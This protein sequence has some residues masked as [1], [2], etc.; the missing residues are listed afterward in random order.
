MEY[1]ECIWWNVSKIG[2]YLDLW[3]RNKLWSKPIISQFKRIQ[4]F[5]RGNGCVKKPQAAH[6]YPQ[7]QVQTGFLA[8]LYS[9]SWRLKSAFCHFWTVASSLVGSRDSLLAKNSFHVRISNIQTLNNSETSQKNML[10]SS[11]F[12]LGKQQTWKFANATC[13]WIVRYIAI[14]YLY[15]D[16][17]IQQQHIFPIYIPLYHP[18]F[19]SGLKS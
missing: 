19:L 7:S 17:S 3:L 10:R 11:C 15:H 5:A 4:K 16:P 13:F 1:M 2:R 8:L 12:D 9:L 6:P 18:I 14:P